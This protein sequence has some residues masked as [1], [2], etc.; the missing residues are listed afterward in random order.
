MTIGNSQPKPN[1]AASPAPDAGHLL[2]CAEEAVRAR[3]VFLAV[4]SHELRTPLTPLRLNLQLLQRE[5]AGRPELEHLSRQVEV[6][7][8]QIDRLSSLAENLLDIARGTLGWRLPIEARAVDLTELA[9]EVAARFAGEAARARSPIE[10]RLDAPAIGWIDP[11]RIALVL[12]SLL[13]NAIKYGAG[14]P[15]TVRVRSRPGWVRVSVEDQGIGIAKEEKDRI[16]G[17][18]ERAVSE[19]RYGGLGLGLYIAKQIVDAHGGRIACSSEPGRGATFEVDLPAADGRVGAAPEV[20]GR[21][22]PDA[23]AKAGDAS[24]AEPLDPGHEDV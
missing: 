10:L 2:A 23:G 13:S 20:Y 4:A 18:F 24:A 16:F 11:A 21:A 7:L 15:V 3:D 1:Q 14:R 22:G 19:R 9:R 6:A 8:R 17:L 12:A 5:L